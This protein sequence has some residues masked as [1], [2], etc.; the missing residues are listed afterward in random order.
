MAGLGKPEDYE[1]VP[2]WILEVIEVWDQIGEVV[3]R[4][5][6]AVVRRLIHEGKA[7]AFSSADLAKYGLDPKE[8]RSKLEAE[9]ARYLPGPVRVHVDK[10]YTFI[11][12]RV[13]KSE[14]KAPATVASLTT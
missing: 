11:L 3:D 6:K 2:S 13:A 8:K 9:L 14:A 4:E 1:A 12:R 7:Y 10:G 5:G